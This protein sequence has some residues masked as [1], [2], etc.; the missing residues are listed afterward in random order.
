M[1]PSLKFSDKIN[2]SL[3]NGHL[4]IL[5]DNSRGIQGCPGAVHLIYCNQMIFV[6]K[7]VCMKN[8]CSPEL[9]TTNINLFLID[10]NFEKKLQ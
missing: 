1:S 7:K 6:Q 3:Y 2:V 10:L 8:K 5:G 4:Q 9:P